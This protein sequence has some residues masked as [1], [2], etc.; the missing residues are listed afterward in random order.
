MAHTVVL[1][2][3]IPHLVQLVLH[4]RYMVVLQLYIPRIVLLL[5]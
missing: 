5:L 1:L 4:R 2:L 3:Y